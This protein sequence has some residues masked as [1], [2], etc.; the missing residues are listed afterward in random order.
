MAALIIGNYINDYLNYENTNDVGKNINGIL[1]IDLK[2]KQILSIIESDYYINKIFLISGGLLVY[3]SKERKINILKYFN[4]NGKYIEIVLNQ[5][6]KFYF[7]ADNF[8]FCMED[9]CTDN[10]NKNKEN[11]NEDELLLLSELRGGI[12]A[13]AKNQL[14]KLY[15]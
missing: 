4:Q 12:I 8:D 10:E 11:D 14:I 6:S 15:K 2:N 1:L 7:N 5:K 13:L 9:F 3:N